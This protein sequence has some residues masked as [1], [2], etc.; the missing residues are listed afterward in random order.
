MLKIE[1]FSKSYDGGKTFAV[2]NLNLTI[3]EGEIVAFIGR[4]GSGKTT[5]IKAIAGIINFDKGDIFVNDISVRTDPIAVKNQIAYLPETLQIFEYL[6]GIDFLNFIANVYNVSSEDRKEKIEKFSK[7]FSMENALNHTIDTYSHGMKQKIAIIG[8]LLHKSNLILLDE[9]FYGLDPQSSYD[10]KQILNELVKNGASVFY[11]TH[12][13]DVAE[14]MAHSVVIIDKGKIIKQGNMKEL[15]GDKSLE[16][17][18]LELNKN[19]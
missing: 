11:S 8:T 17:L 2:D 16:Q 7:L 6:S 12:V 13:L 14:K 1:N 10:F 15:K 4:N 19:D 18:F 9:P 3:K 5:T